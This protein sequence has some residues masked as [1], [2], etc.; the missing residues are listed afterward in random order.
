[1]QQSASR[2]RARTQLPPRYWEPAPSAAPQGGIRPEHIRWVLEPP[3]GR[4]AVRQ[5][6]VAKG[7]AVS[8]AGPGGGAGAGDSKESPAL[9]GSNSSCCGRSSSSSSGSTT[10]RGSGAGSGIGSSKSSGQ[11]GGECEGGVGSPLTSLESAST[12][13]SQTG[14]SATPSTAFPLSPGSDQPPPALTQPGMGACK[15]ESAKPGN[16]ASSGTDSVGDQPKLHS[17][18]ADAQLDVGGGRPQAWHGG[19]VVGGEEKP[20]TLPLR[21]AKRAQSMFPRRHLF[22][23][24][25]VTK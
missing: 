9:A 10:S 23:K 20:E 3:K 18:S 22:V 1:M 19:E 8:T 21:L 12:H 25:Q 15:Q 17:D 11:G 5:A 2:E 4:P 7:H 16:L 6:A 24:A 14:G 13:S